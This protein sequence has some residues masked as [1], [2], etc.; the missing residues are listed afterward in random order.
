MAIER[1]L[2]VL[3]ITDHDSVS[4]VAEALEAASGSPLTVI[5][6]VEYSAVS[7]DDHVHV[8]SYF[9]DHTDP[10][11]TAMLEDLR[12]A[13]V[14]RARDTVE[15][16][17]AAGYS[18]SLADVLTLSDGGAVGRSHIARA[19]VDSGAAESVSDAFNRLVGRG[20]PFYVPKDTTSPETLVSQMREAGAIPVLAHPGVSGA[21]DLIPSLVEAGL[22]GIEAFHAEH[23]EG[24]RTRY[25]RLA[26]DLGLLATGGSD[27]HG[28]FAPNAALG[29][30]DVPDWAVRALLE[31]GECG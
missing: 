1:G 13:R 30:V 23:T 8:L 4:G 7:G 2:D 15:A 6:A 11:L 24:Q 3:A 14:R 29:S 10:A 28:P 26:A 25:A 9:V 31:A 12:D 18:I 19:L 27:F 5:A 16:L 21:D 22:L 17:S 20:M